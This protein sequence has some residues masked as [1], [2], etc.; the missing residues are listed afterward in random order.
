MPALSG[1]GT[2]TGMP[3]VR[4]QRPKRFNYRALPVWL[5][6]VLPFGIAIIAV[7]ALVLYVQHQT[8]DTPSEAPVNSPS[9]IVEQN[10]EAAVLMAQYQAPHYATL[11]TGATPA[12]GL[13]V[14]ITRWLDHQISIGTYNGPLTGGSCVDTAG[15]TSA[16]VALKCDMVT[17]NVTYP[18]YGVVVPATKQIAYCQ[19]VAPAQYGGKNLALSKRC[20][21]A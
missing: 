12:A 21:A 15:S 18:F 8:N 11:A 6:W 5:Q 13:K 14:A 10:R 3:A 4:Q 20:L 19:K 17:A 7:V 16:R 9:A 2:L 1:A